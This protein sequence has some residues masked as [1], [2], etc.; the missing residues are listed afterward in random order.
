M[1]HVPEAGRPGA[2]RRATLRPRPASLTATVGRRA[3]PLG[4]RAGEDAR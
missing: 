3:F 4:G 2:R 1:G